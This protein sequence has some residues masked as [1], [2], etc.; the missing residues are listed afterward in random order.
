MESR[1][2]RFSWRASTQK[3]RTRETPS[4][5][6]V[7]T[8]APTKSQRGAT[9]DLPVKSHEF[10]TPMLPTGSP[11]GVRAQAPPA[12]RMNEAYQVPLDPSLRTRVHI[13]TPDQSSNYTRATLQ[14][15]TSEHSARTRLDRRSRQRYRVDKIAHVGSDMRVAPFISTSV[16]KAG[17][18]RASCQQPY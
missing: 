13:P 18:A 15:F 8:R 10:A 9:Q 6:H 7:A 1:A 11:A 12:V 3:H 14:R 4:N 16:R 5:T 2:R 17:T